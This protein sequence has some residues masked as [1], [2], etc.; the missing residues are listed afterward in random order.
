MQNA[1]TTMATSNV[2]LFGGLKRFEKVYIFSAGVIMDERPETEWPAVELMVGPLDDP[3]EH[4]E[5]LSEMMGID[6]CRP[7]WEEIEKLNGFL[8][9]FA[10]E[11]CR[12]AMGYSEVGIETDTT[13]VWNY[14]QEALEF[15]YSAD[16]L[17][18]PLINQLSLRSRKDD[19]V[20]MWMGEADVMVGFL[21]ADAG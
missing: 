12:E 17:A 5:I 3:V 6:V 16:P 14:F 13:S 18:H 10:N 19:E 4:F 8:E 20:E 21:K 7:S 11:K 15:Y 9:F 2:D 1:T